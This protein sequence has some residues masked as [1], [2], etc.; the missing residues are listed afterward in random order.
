MMPSRDGA[1]RELIEVMDQFTLLSDGAT[2]AV[3][4]PDLES[5]ERA[6]DARDI[7][8]A[9]ARELV[10]IL[11]EGEVVPAEVR[12]RLTRLAQADEE[13]TAVAQRARAE[14]RSELDRIGNS[15]VAVGGYAAAM[16]RFRRLDL[17][18]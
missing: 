14:T 15:R 7:V 13:L 1:I 5:L 11:N 8:L 4:A 16:P 2:Q 17:R 3:L 18:R 12:E 6:L 9:R 10:P